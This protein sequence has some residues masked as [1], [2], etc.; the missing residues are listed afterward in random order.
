MDKSVEF[1]YEELAKATDGFNMANIIGQGGLG[2]VYNVEEL[3]DKMNAK[4]HVEPAVGIDVDNIPLGM[5]EN[6]YFSDT[7]V[8]RNYIPSEGEV[9]EEG[10]ENI[11]G[12]QYE[13][14]SDEEEDLGLSDVDLEDLGAT[15]DTDSEGELFDLNKNIEEKRFH[16]D[17]NGKVKLEKNG[18]FVD[19]YE[20]RAALKDYIIQ[21]CFDI[22]YIKNEKTRVTE[23]CEAEGCPWRIHASTTPDGATFMIKSVNNV[24]TCVRNSMRNYATSTWIT[25]KL[26]SGLRADPY[27]SYNLM[28]NELKEKYGIEPHPMQLYRTRMKVMEEVEGTHEVQAVIQV[29]PQAWHRCCAKYLFNNFKARYPHEAVFAPSEKQFKEAMEKMSKVNNNAAKYLMETSVDAWSRHAFDPASKSPHVTNNMCESF[30][31]WVNKLRDKPPLILLDEMR[32]K[33]MIRWQKRYEKGCT[34]IEKVL[35]KIAKE[36]SMINIESRACIVYGAGRDQYE[37][38]DGKNRHVVDLQGK[39]CGCTQWQISGLPCIHTSAVIRDKRVRIED[40][41]D[42]YYSPIAF[43]RSY[44][45]IIHP[46]PSVEDLLE[47]DVLAPPLRRLPGRQKKNRK[48]AKDETT[49]STIKKRLAMGSTTTSSQTNMSAQQKLKLKMMEKKS[50]KNGMQQNQQGSQQRAHKNSQEANRPRS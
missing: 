5:D 47:S 16:S 9:D 17:D 25:S 39:T 28:K 19:V 41:V 4:H 37:V 46:L 14:L 49:P 3:R 20:F 29:F 50:K 15:N 33:L 7:D 31:Q 35:P 26:Y 36:L 12:E 21:E 1:L 30:N 48:R 22:G 23:I 40:Y 34:C 38:N 32:I 6:F 42:V 27:M 45:I 24:H 44:D 10:N 2:S 43:V 8:D 13:S 11:D 18:F